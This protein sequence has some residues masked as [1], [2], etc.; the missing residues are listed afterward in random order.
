MKVSAAG[1]A[2]ITQRE[3][4]RL[5]AYR[6][7]RGIPTIGVGHVDMTPPK[8]VM[9]M[10]IT[11]AQA[12]ALLAADLAPVE[13]TINKSVTVS[14]TQNEFDALASLGFNIG[15]GGL[16]RSTVVGRLNRGDRAGA[17]QAF[18][19][20]AHPAELM[21]RRKAEVAQFLKPD[22]VVAVAVVAVAVEAP[23]LPATATPAARAAATAPK[24]PLILQPRAP[25]PAPAAPGLISR[26]V[27]SLGSLFG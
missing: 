1:R 26:V 12:D 21:G 18:L 8:T 4:C 19:L 27:G 14:L 3:G 16:A 6:D 20:W 7:S 25:A 10:R 5:V 22:A 11:A 23:L 24:T 17:A 2:A 9:G 13:A 15:I